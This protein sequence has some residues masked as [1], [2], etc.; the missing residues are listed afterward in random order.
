[1][2]KHAKSTQTLIWDRILQH[3]PGWPFTPASFVDLGTPAGVRLTLHRLKKSGT[4]RPIGRGLYDYPKQDPQL[5]ALS[6]SADAVVQALKG[7]DAVRLQPTGAHAANLLGLS[8]QVPVRL[9]Y[10]TDG[11]TRSLKLGKQV[12]QFRRT[13]PRNLA[14]AGRTS[15][16]VIQALRQLG[17][18]AVTDDVIRHLDGKLSV[19]DKAQ[20]QADLAYA[21]QWMAPIFKK[22]APPVAT[23]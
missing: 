12:I 7:R 16:L 9:V 6:P 10:Q 2:G 22:L 3:G 15:G 14:T 23:A 5:G 19:A 17:K 20:L 21:P 11:R 8:T 18:D 1:M 13:T 4:I